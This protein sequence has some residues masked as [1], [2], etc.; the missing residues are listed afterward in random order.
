M[1]KLLFC[2]FLFLSFNVFGQEFNSFL[3][4]ASFS[5]E[6]SYRTL[7][8]INDELVNFRNKNEIGKFGYTTGISIISNVSKLFG[9][10]IGIQYSNKGYQTKKP[11]LIM[12]PEPW[13]PYERNVTYEY[14]YLDIPLKANF[15]FG[16]NRLRYIA[17]AGIIINFPISG[18]N[19]DFDFSPTIGAGIEYKI[20]DKLILRAI[21][22]FKHGIL[23]NGLVS[24]N[25]RKAYN[26]YLWSAGIEIGIF[27]GIK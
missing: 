15:T 19:S 12:M 23:S 14:E 8:G 16:E 1:K 10:E 18:N 13:F 4:G 22:N 9:I 27:Y 24:S 6:Y 11:I 2:S 3:I 25:N 17:T 26:E 5:P 7:T 20:T 21:P